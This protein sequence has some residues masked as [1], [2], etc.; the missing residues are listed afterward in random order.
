MFHAP[1]WILIVGFLIMMAVTIKIKGFSFID[2][3]LFTM[4]T[5]VSFFFDMIFCKWLLYYAY[6]TIDDIK[7]F[8]SLIFCIIGYPALGLTFVK[9]IPSSRGKIIIYTLAW[10]AAL[11]LLELLLVPYEIVIYIEWKIIPFSPLIY[12]L[13]FAWTYGYYR[14]LKKYIPQKQ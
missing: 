1:F 13:S 10:S 12:I 7:A 11:T 5:A 3:Q 4:I 9:F 2:L 8:Y 6:V 14:I